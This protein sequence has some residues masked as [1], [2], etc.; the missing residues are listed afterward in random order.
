LE[1][2]KECL[3]IAPE[4]AVSMETNGPKLLGMADKI[5]ELQ[6]TKGLIP[7]GGIGY[8]DDDDDDD[9]DGDGD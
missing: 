2:R 6:Q 1:I 3:E 7:D 9:D 4:A 8:D 5:E